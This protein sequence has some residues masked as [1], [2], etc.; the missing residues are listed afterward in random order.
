[1]LLPQSQQIKQEKRNGVGGARRASERGGGDSPRGLEAQNGKLKGAIHCNHKS[2]V[3]G[4]QTQSSERR[5]HRCPLL[6]SSPSPLRLRIAPHFNA[7]L[8]KPTTR[9]TRDVK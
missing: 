6:L 9:F 2:Q 8:I 7:T 3:G 4:K 1:M 5:Y